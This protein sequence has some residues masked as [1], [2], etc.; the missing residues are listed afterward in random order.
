MLKG[1]GAQ[2][3]P[4]PSRRWPTVANRHRQA[5]IDEAARIVELID[6]DFLDLMQEEVI[7][8][9]DE[10]IMSIRHNPAKSLRHMQNARRSIETIL[11]SAELVHSRAGAIVQ[12]LESAPAV[13]DEVAS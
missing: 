8:E 3:K 4:R 1:T 10:A 7:V 6:S 12:V 11:R 5:A 13:G 9:I 2:R